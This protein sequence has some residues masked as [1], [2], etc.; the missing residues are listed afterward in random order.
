M[1]LCNA[2][3]PLDVPLRPFYKKL[4]TLWYHYIRFS[5]VLHIGFIYVTN[6]LVY[7]FSTL[8]TLV[9]QDQPYLFATIFTEQA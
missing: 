3:R 1:W 4:N 2:S 7:F 6:L 5:K 9:T 8:Q